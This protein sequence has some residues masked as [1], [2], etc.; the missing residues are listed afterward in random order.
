MN[1][2][3][4]LL[5]L[6]SLIVVGFVLIW[7][8][9][10]WLLSWL[11]GWQR[12]ALYYRASAPPQGQPASPLW[13]M[14][15]PVSHRGTLTVQAAPE[16]LYLSVMVLFRLG[17]PP[18][19]IPWSAVRGGGA[20]QGFLTKWLTFDLG[21]PKCATLRIPAGQVDEEVLARYLGTASR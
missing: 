14:L 13:A 1:D 2:S 17:H 21:E 10:I 6:V 12:L 7:G 20:P 8:G 18:L 4:L 9:V 11:S 15:G 5:F 16:G 3:L 19:L